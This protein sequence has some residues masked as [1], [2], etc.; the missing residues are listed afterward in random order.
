MQGHERPTLGADVGDHEA[1][2]GKRDVDGAGEEGRRQDGDDRHRPDDQ[3]DGAD[4]S[5]L[6]AS[7]AVRSLSVW[8]NG[9][10][11]GKSARRPGFNRCEIKYCG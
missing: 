10:L 8:H 9:Q 4:R 5:D 1:R 3:Q 6:K 11:S 2:S 7:R